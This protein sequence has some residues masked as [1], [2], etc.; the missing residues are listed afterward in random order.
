M[1][2]QEFLDELG[3]RIGMLEDSEQQD[4]LAEYAQHIDLRISSGLSE[5]DAI[6]DFGNF[7]QLVSEILG[8]YHVKPDF[9]KET[10]PDTTSPRFSAASFSSVGGKVWQKL[11]A[12]GTA[13]K[14]FFIR[15]GRRI[16]NWFCHAAVKVKG[17]FSKKTSGSS[18]HPVPVREKAHGSR[19]AAFGSFLRRMMNQLGRLCMIMLRLGWNFCLLLCSAPFLIMTLALVLM[20]GMFIILLLQGYPFLGIVLCTLGGIVSCIAVLG[21]GWTLVW[22]RPGKEEKNHEEIK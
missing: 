22:H 11:K 10:A 5:E 14:N 20:I 2:K 18:D 16:R 17:W 8:A 21:L 6:R 4:I 13:V 1:K 9:L 12:A 3:K 19:L 7:D 15:S